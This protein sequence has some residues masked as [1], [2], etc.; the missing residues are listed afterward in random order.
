MVEKEQVLETEKR[1]HR[2]MAGLWDSLCPD[3]IYSFYPKHDGKSLKGF[4]IISVAWMNTTGV[5]Y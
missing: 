3:K 5:E 4:K 2:W 1:L